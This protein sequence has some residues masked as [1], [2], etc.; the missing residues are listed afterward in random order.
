MLV[1]RTKVKG[2]SLVEMMI[3]M[4]LGLASITAMA[5]L[6]GHGI[7][8]NS[9]LLAKSRLD[10]EI[11]AVMAVMTDDLK[12][13]GF[14]GLTQPMLD[15]PN[16]FIN[17]FASVLSV[18]AYSKE[19]AN[20]CITYAYDQNQNG[21]LDTKDSNE[22]FGFRLKDKAIEMR[23]AGWSCEENGWHDLTDP[24]VIKITELQFELKKHQVLQLSHSQIQ[25]S[26][27]AQLIKYPELSKHVQATVLLANY[28]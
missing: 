11:N 7:G 5:S 12:R 24:S 1:L 3:A 21:L 28:D 14:H 6:V 9:S 18:S 8:L 17:P 16:H 19:S 22:N 25:I 23:L 27:H 4:T 10:E 26:L 13:A 15:T 20:S 2:N